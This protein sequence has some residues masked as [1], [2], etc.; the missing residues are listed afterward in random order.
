V[1]RPA[2]F[3]VG[4]EIAGHLARSAATAGQLERAIALV[5]AQLRTEPPALRTL[6]PSAGTTELPPL[7]AAVAGPFADL[8]ELSALLYEG[9]GAASR[10]DGERR[11]ARLLRIVAAQFRARSS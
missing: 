2:D 5:E 3:G 1:P 8:H 10:A 4:N 7:A 9:R 11:Q 6:D